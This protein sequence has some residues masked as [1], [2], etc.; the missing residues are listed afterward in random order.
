M[1]MCECA[2]ARVHVCVCVEPLESQGIFL[3]F[4]WRGPVQAYPPKGSLLFS[5]WFAFMMVHMVLLLA[6]RVLSFAGLQPCCDDLHPT[7]DGLQP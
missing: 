4:K 6:F 1:C 3:V 7:S 2:P 5:P